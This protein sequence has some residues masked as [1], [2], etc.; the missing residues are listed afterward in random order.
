VAVHFAGPRVVVVAS[1]ESMK[2]C[3][4]QAAKPEKTGP[5]TPVIAKIEDKF[6]VVAG[7]NPKGG[8]LERLGDNNPLKSL[9]E[10]ELGQATLAVVPG[11]D[12]Q[13]EARTT[14]KDEK[15]AKDSAG[16][17][18]VLIG[19]ARLLYLLP[20]RLKGGD[21]AKLAAQ[22]DKLLGALKIAPKGKDVV[23]TAKADTA[24][25]VAALLLASKQANR[26]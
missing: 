26:R 3:M 18:G 9:P 12:A 10:M 7:L 21:E 2:R 6:Q 19:G 24:T 8:S 25:V 14:M 13:L 23:V 1:V 17:L 11:G 15:S 5:L 16:Q 22:I 4:A 20:M